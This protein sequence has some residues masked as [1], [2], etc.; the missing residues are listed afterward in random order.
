MLCGGLRV[1]VFG[2]FKRTVRNW[3]DTIVRTQH[4]LG[5]EV[6]S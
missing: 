2:L 4:L 5:M 6:E 1:V 3:R